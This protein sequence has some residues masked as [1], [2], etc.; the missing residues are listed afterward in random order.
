MKKL[1]IVL[2]VT[3]TISS[4]KKKAEPTTPIQNVKEEIST[5]VDPFV[6][7]IEVAHKKETLQKYEGIKYDISITF[8]GNLIL[9]AL[10]T[11]SIDSRYSK[12]ELKNGE[13]IYINDDK[14]YVSPGLKDENSVRF[15]AY[16]WN[17]FFLFPYKLNDEGTKWSEY[18]PSKVEASFNAKKLSFESGIG[19]APEDWYIVYSNKSTNIIEH[20]AYIVT[21]GKTKEAAEADPHAIQYSGYKSINGVPF[22][23]NW[24]FL[25]WN[26]K[27][28]L[29]NVIGHA[30][31]NTIK[32]VD[33]LGEL[34]T[35]PEGFVEK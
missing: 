19:D 28:S 7:S 11:T 35:I 3:L 23:H 2:I 4:C 9:D 27:E 12:I 33:D 16:T 21:Y 13:S 30:E 34:L 22:A 14:V 20:V 26:P 8:G 6:N 10:I 5:S 17:Y 29:T 25:E 15:S 32:F 31:L 24:T 1:V 18:T